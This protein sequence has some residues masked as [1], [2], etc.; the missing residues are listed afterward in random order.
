MRR[1]LQHRIS[2]RSSGQDFRF[3]L[4][5]TGLGTI[6]TMAEVHAAVLAVEAGQSL[7]FDQAA[8]VAAA[9]K[10]GI[11]VVGLRCENDELPAQCAGCI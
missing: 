11:V 6:A 8:M 9:N 7:L 4:P 1:R 5:A 10:A 2:D 3:D